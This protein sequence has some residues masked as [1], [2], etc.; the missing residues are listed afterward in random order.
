[1]I[2]AKDMITCLDHLP[3]LIN[4][5]HTSHDLS[6]LLRKVG[7]MLLDSK[8][9]NFYQWEGDVQVKWTWALSLRFTP[10][11]GNTLLEDR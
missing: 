2:R 7:E 10:P 6:S 8:Q 3:C 9:L 11:L 4:N 1:M 5:H